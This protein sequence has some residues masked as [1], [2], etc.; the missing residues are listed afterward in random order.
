[1]CTARNSGKN[2]RIVT[3]LKEK[4]LGLLVGGPGY[5]TGNPFLPRAILR[6]L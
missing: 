2:G 4:A 1:M 6:N 3:D 5:Y